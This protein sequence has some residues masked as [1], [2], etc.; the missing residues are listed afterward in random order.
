M[1]VIPESIPAQVLFF[2]NSGII[3]GQGVR[4]NCG[5][6]TSGT[7]SASTLPCPTS[8]YLDDGEYDFSVDHTQIQ[9]VLLAEDTI[10][11]DSYK[12]DGTIPSLFELITSS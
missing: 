7:T 2:L 5:C 9:Q 8:Y 4:L 6:A 1:G 3:D 11:T 10:C 12:L